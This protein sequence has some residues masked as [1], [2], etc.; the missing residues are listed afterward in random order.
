MDIYLMNASYKRECAKNVFYPRYYLTSML[1]LEYLLE[2]WKGGVNLGG[3]KHLT[4]IQRTRLHPFLEESTNLLRKPNAESA[5]V[6]LMVNYFKTMTMVIDH[7]QQFPE[8]WTIARYRVL[9]STICLRSGFQE[10]QNHSM[11]VSFT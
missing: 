1:N 9:S 3:L 10:K 11:S 5:K 8:M 7:Q 4:W 6:A 2:D